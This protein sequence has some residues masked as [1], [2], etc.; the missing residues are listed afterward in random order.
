MECDDSLRAVQSQTTRVSLIRSTATPPVSPTTSPF[1]EAKYEGTPVYQIDWTIVAVCSGLLFML[2]VSLRGF[3]S[4]Q[5]RAATS[6]T[7]ALVDDFGAPKP[8]SEQ[9]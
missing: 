4:I 2:A 8:P 6:R 1:F 9:T 5:Q 7:R 3:V